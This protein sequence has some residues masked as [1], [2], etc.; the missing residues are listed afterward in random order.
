MEITATLVKELREKTGVGMMECKSALT[1]SKGDLAGAEKILRTKGLAAAAKKSSRATAEGAIGSYIHAGGKLGVMVEVNCETDFVARTDQFQALLKDIA[2]HVAA[3]N[4]R[5]VSR[6]EVTP[7]VLES[8]RAIYRAQAAASGKPP[9]VVEKI[10]DGKLEKFYEEFCLLEQPFVKDQETTV[11]N[12]I[13]A[14]VAKIGENVRVRRFAR[15]QL[16]EEPSGKAE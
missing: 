7:A 16:G 14:L 2:M 8:E 9:A 12:M 15:F 4:P 5:F 10:I 3:A 13:A 11:G 6:D 1:E